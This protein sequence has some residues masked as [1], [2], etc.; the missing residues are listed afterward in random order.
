MASLTGNQIN[1]SYQGL[2]KSDNNGAISGLTNITDG[3]GN[4]TGLFLDPSA[5]TV[6]ISGSA[7]LFNIK[8]TGLNKTT[9]PMGSVA[10][11]INFQDVN[12]LDI[13]DIGQDSYGSSYYTNI[14]GDQG[15]QHIF[16]SRNQAG[17]IVTSKISMNGYNNVNNSDNWFTGYNERIT[18]EA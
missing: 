11:Q 6:G 14:N 15:E 7:T 18:A 12:G 17:T 9:Y 5:N 2:L 4:Q 10:T 13:F 1:N 3:L 8:N 16:R